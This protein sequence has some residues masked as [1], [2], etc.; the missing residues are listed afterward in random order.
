MSMLLLLL[1]LLLHATVTSAVFDHLLRMRYGD[2]E[3]PR[4]RK[5]MRLD[6]GPGCSIS[7]EDI[8][9]NIADTMQ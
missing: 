7:F 6:A 1:L 4:R 8:K 9:N 2:S 5:K 3:Q